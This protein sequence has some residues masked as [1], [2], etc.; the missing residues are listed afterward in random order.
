[1][2]RQESKQDRDEQDRDGEREEDDPADAR[3]GR[4]VTRFRVVLHS[5]KTEPP[6]LYPLSTAFAVLVFL[7]VYLGIISSQSWTA[8][9]GVPE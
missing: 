4:F 3:E 6:G 9:D 5:S 8:S 7:L 1:L 2:P